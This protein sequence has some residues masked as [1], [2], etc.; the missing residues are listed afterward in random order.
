MVGSPKSPERKDNKAS[1]P[2][3]KSPAKLEDPIGSSSS[4]EGV[5][6]E[7]LTGEESVRSKSRSPIQRR[8]YGQKQKKKFAK[9]YGGPRVRFEKPLVKSPPAD[10]AKGKAKGS[11]KKQEKGPPGKSM[12]GG[13]RNAKGKGKGKQKGKGKRKGK[14]KANR[15]QPGGA[16]RVGDNR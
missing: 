1:P 5:E 8:G 2:R 6:E 14:T 12:P 11:G 9:R 13:K 10:R 4:E 7:S 16:P 15:G 3:P